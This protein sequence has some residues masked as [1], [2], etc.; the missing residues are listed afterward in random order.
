MSGVRIRGGTV[1]AHFLE[2]ALRRVARQSLRQC[3]ARSLLDSR[4]SSIALRLAAAVSDDHGVG[5]VSTLSTDSGLGQELQSGT[6]VGVHAAPF[7]EHAVGERFPAA[8]AVP[9]LAIEREPER[10]IEVERRT[11]TLVLGFLPRLLAKGRAGVVEV[12]SEWG[13]DRRV[14]SDG[15]AEFG[16]GPRE[17]RRTVG[18][19]ARG[20]D[21]GE[22]PERIHAE[23]PRPEPP[24]DRRRLL[25]A[26]E[27]VLEIAFEQ[28]DP[29]EIGQRSA[30]SARVV[31]EA[32]EL[33]RLVQPAASLSGVP[34][35]Q[36]V[37][38]EV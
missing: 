9:C 36:G 32:G 35:L 16:R 13:H 3:P 4:P 14:V 6:V 15:S 26:R 28:F 21:L 11:G 37:P 25:E 34:A 18:V 33:E 17:A 7:L 1:S 20:C 24:S 5:C 10:G 22:A 31:D 12:R 23:P 29:A 30:G 8:G 19:A 27:R 2:V 38:R